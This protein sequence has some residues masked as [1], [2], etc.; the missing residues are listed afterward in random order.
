MKYLLFLILL[1]AIPMALAEV[2]C[3]KVF[4]VNFEYDDGVITPKEKALKC[5]YAPDRIIQPEDGYIA[6]IIS[7][8]DKPLY[9]F[10]FKIPLKANV[11]MSDPLLNGLSGGMIILSKTDFALIFPYYDQA[12]NIVIYNPRK[13]KAANVPLIE[14]QFMQKRSTWWILLLILALI[15]AAYAVYRYYKKREFGTT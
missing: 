14:E 3:S 2:E 9:S 10:R 6:E 8:D 4:V 7:M 11:D 5:G 15:I 12:K 13:Y 1:L